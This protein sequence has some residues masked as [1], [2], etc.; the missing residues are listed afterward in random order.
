MVKVVVN[1]VVAAVEVE[2]EVEEAVEEVA[3]KIFLT[4]LRQHLLHLS[5]QLISFVG[6]AA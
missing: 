5:S 1:M 6:H 3:E 2:D 4:A